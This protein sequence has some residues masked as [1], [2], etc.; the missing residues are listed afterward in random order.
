[1]RSKLAEKLPQAAVEYLLSLLQEYP[2]QVKIVKNRTSKAG[3]FRA[4]FKDKPARITVNGSLNPFAF[5]ITLVHE[6]AHQHVWMNHEKASRK[7]TFRRKSKPLPHGR[8]W[9]EQFRRLMLP[10][11]K[12]DVFPEDILPVLNRYLDNPKASSSVDHLL[13]K[14]LKKHDPPDHAMRLEELP[15]DAVFSIHGKRSF[16]KKEKIRT[17]YRC[18]CLK[19]NRIYLV[20]A[21]A[22]VVPCNLNSVA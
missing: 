7:F 15:F 18:I 21:G 8:E 20:S 9:K 17:R 16:R 6:M 13:S 19:T 4:T 1:M 14:V 3:D 12:P 2:I 22:P 11:Q 5:L 10:I